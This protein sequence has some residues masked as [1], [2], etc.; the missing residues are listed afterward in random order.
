[1]VSISLHSLPEANVLAD[2]ATASPEVIPK[3][4]VNDD[5]TRIS[6]RGGKTSV[7]SS[8]E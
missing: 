8:D 4:R 1:L 3:R 2:R 6:K 7:K 5:Y